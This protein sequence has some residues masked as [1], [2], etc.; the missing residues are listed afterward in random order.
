MVN[1]DTIQ[2]P[3]ELKEE[4]YHMIS[5]LCAVGNNRDV[6]TPAQLIN[7]L[8]KKNAE[9]ESDL[10]QYSEANKTHAIENARLIEERDEARAHIWQKPQPGEVRTIPAS[11]KL[12][13][14]KHAGK[15]VSITVME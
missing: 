5:Q 3:R 1:K 6:K 8:I 11:G 13:L 7:Y 10:I 4:M 12:S 15:K 2:L 9:L 14:E